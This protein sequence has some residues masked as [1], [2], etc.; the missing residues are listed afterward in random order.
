L[1]ARSPTLKERSECSVRVLLVHLEGCPMSIGAI[2]DREPA[3]RYY[4][5][6]RCDENCLGRGGESA[7]F[8]DADARRVGKVDYDQRCM[9]SG[10]QRARGVHTYCAALRTGCLQCTYH[11]F[12]ERSV[13]REHGT[14]ADTGT[15]QGPTPSEVANVFPPLECQA[16]SNG[17]LSGYEPGR[18]GYTPIRTLVVGG[19]WGALCLHPHGRPA[20][21]EP[22]ATPTG[23]VAGRHDLIHPERRRLRC[24]NVHEF[25]CYSR[26]LD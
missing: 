6:V 26:Y 21:A 25:V 15:K 4:A 16:G 22:S 8:A 18:T 24:S 2:Q 5:V 1:D 14:D 11:L 20:T 17:A 19:G 9:S 23:M 3:C 10:A 12:G 13:T 7:R